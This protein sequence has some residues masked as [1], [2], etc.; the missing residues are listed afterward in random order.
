MFESSKLIL[1]L[2]HLCI[3]RTFVE[4]QRRCIL[5]YS[6]LKHKFVFSINRRLHCIGFPLLKH[7]NGYIKDNYDCQRNSPS[8]SCNDGYPSSGSVASPNHQDY[9]NLDLNDLLSGRAN[10]IQNS[11]AIPMQM[12]L[13]PLVPTPTILTMAG[14]ESHSE[15]TTGTDGKSL[16]AAPMMVRLDDRARCGD[17][18][19]RLPDRSRDR[20]LWS[21]PMGARLDSVG[22]QSRTQCDYKSFLSREQSRHRDRQVAQSS[23]IISSRNQTLQQRQSNGAYTNHFWSSAAGGKLCAAGGHASRLLLRNPLICS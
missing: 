17:L 7:K 18:Q 5:W 8:N 2:N 13:L 11:L 1:R 3:I 15:P 23:Q 22:S 9:V 4:I 10:F 19:P 21:C 12:L 6:R 20:D 14:S 16:L